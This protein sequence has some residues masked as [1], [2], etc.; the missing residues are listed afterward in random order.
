MQS[1]AAGSLF[2]SLTVCLAEFASSTAG[3]YE[4]NS[5]LVTLSSLAAGSDLLLAEAARQVGAA[6]QVVLPFD[7]KEFER[8][9]DGATGDLARHRDLLASAERTFVHD[10]RRG[11]AASDIDMQMRKRAYRETGRTLVRH[12]DLLVAIWDGDEAHGVGGTAEQVEYALAFGIPVAWI[13]SPSK[14]A[15]IPGHPAPVDPQA[16]APIRWLSD[17]ADLL[18]LHRPNPLDMDQL[19]ARLRQHVNRVLELPARSEPEEEQHGSGFPWHPLAVLETRH[20]S[21][22]TQLSAFYGEGYHQAGRVGRS[23]AVMLH[24]LRLHDHIRDLLYPRRRVAEVEGTTLSR[25]GE[26]LDGCTWKAIQEPPNPEAIAQIDGVA[27]MFRRAY[28]VP[29]LVATSLAQAIRTITMVVTGLAAA[30]IVCAALALVHQEWKTGLALAELLILAIVM[31]IVGYANHW[32]LKERW[33][34]YRLLAELLRINEALAP[35]GRTL[36]MSVSAG[37]AHVGGA[38]PK[39]VTWYV[40]AVIRDIGLATQDHGHRASRIAITATACR[41]L[42]LGQIMYH[43]RNT[44]RVK[45]MDSVADAFGQWMAVVTIAVLALKLGFIAF[46]HDGRSFARLVS[47][48]ISAPTE[49]VAKSWKL[50]QAWMTLLTVLMPVVAAS[51]FALRHVEEWAFLAQRSRAMGDSLTESLTDDLGPTLSMLVRDGPQDSLIMVEAANGMVR[52]G[53][54]MVSEVGNWLAIVDTKRLE[55]A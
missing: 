26:R 13:H 31:A 33:Q 45:R 48:A 11:D 3:A 16:A 55:A 17:P 53:R 19:R 47:L 9:F 27:N 6:L 22:E 32:R 50:V 8:D 4:G 49:Q 54:K 23:T 5:K 38:V 24:V 37:E 43:R 10:G 7:P 18:L 29:D 52:V 15:D 36:P 39:W 44:A 14:Q 35:F 46:D 42:L 25:L 40:N 2:R 1:K 20:A 21:Q 41:D 51:V 34:H 28:A 12:C 30:A